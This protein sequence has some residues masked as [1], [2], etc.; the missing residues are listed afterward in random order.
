MELVKADYYITT[1]EGKNERVTLPTD[2][3]EWLYE[4]LQSQGMNLE[5]VQEQTLAGQAEIGQANM[6]MA[7][8]PQ[9]VPDLMN[10]PI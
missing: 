8:P 2:A 6:E 10:A 3:I 7:Q 9:M 1:P 4:K 5:R